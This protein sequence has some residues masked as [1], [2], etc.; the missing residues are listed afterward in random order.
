M[1]AALSSTNKLG[2]D[3]FTV[4]GA[5]SIWLI[6]FVIEVISDKQKTEHKVL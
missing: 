5:F 6:D 1:A 4:V 2:L 3:C